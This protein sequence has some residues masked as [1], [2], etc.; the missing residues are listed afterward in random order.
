M[1]VNRRGRPV[2][3]RPF[4]RART[5]VPGRSW[6]GLGL[7]PPPPRWSSNDAPLGR[8]RRCCTR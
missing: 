3:E 5:P 1:Q 6:A 8:D 2:L 4:Q 7:L